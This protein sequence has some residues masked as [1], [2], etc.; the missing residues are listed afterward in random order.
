MLQVIRDLVAEGRRSRA[1]YPIQVLQRP[2]RH[3]APGRGGEQIRVLPD[4]PTRMFVIGT[5][6]AV[7]PEP[8]GFIDEPRTLVRQQGHR[9]GA[10]APVRLYW[11]R[12]DPV[13]GVGDHVQPDVRRRCCA[14]SPTAPDE[15]I[16]RQLGLSLRTVRA[17]GGPDDRARGR[18][19]VPGQASRPVRRGWV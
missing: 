18:Q 11:E 14:S 16:A 12:A 13:L 4:L 6:H 1:I 17:G 19:P 2:R 15:Q 9:G 8:L 3:P 5:T 10:R 7:L